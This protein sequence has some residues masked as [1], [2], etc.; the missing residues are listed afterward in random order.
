MD[1][2]DV[3]TDKRGADCLIHPRRARRS[4]GLS[5]AVITQTAREEGVFMSLLM[6]RARNLAQAPATVPTPGQFRQ[7]VELDAPAPLLATRS[8]T[9]TKPALNTAGGSDYRPGVQV[10]KPS[11]PPMGGATWEV[12]CAPGGADQLSMAIMGVIPARS[13][14]L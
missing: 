6:Q 12:A 4:V 10:P 13:W 8:P 11:R 3:A 14:S 2:Q 9:A 1:Q 7:R 5:L